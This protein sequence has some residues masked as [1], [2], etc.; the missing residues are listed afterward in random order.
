MNVKHFLAQVTADNLL[1]F[2]INWLRFFTFVIIKTHI[3]YVHVA[4]IWPLHS[5]VMPVPGAQRLQRRRF[6][7]AF[8]KGIRPKNKFSQFYCNDEY[9]T[10]FCDSYHVWV[11]S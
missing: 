2:Y 5:P 11:I 4:T 9:M 10:I 8:V 6:L 7:L 3:S 1:R